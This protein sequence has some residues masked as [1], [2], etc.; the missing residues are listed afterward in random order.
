M[1]YKQSKIRTSKPIMLLLALVNF[2][3]IY[4]TNLNAEELIRFDKSSQNLKVQ[5]PLTPNEKNWIKN[6]DPIR[7]AVKSGWMPIEFQLENQLHRGYTIDFLQK[8]ANLY[9]I[10]FE[11]VDYSINIDSS[12]AD[13]ISSISGQNVSNKNFK[14]L[15]QP[16]LIIPNAIYIN[17]NHPKTFNANSLE[18]LKKASVAVYNKG[19][20]PKT[21]KNN[22][23]NLKLVTV[24]I[25]DEAF[26]YLKT[27]AIDAYVGNEFV[28]DYHIDAHHLSFVNKTGLTPFTS[29]ITMAVRD[30]QPELTSIMEKATSIIGQNNQELMKQWRFEKGNLEII[31]E[32][33]SVLIFL[34]FATGAI[35]YYKLKNNAAKALN[36]NQK[37]I[38]HQANFDYL[39]DLPNRNLLQNSLKH[40]IARADGNKSKVALI[41]IDLDNFKHINDNSGHSKGDE[42]LKASA[43]RIAQ[44][45]KMEDITARLGGD[46]FM[47]IVSDFED[48]LSIES[49]C[50]KILNSIQLPFEIGDESFFI[51]ASIGVTIFPDHSTDPEELMSYADQAMYESKKLGRNR[52][53]FFNQSLKIKIANKISMINDLRSAILNHQF[54]LYYQP[55][56][57]MNDS[58]RIK[59]EALIRWNHPQ[60]GIISPFDFIPLAEETGLIIE[61][62]DWIF[63]QATDD[64]KI[65]RNK[66]RSNFHLS[67]NVSPVQ[68]LKSESLTSLVSLVNK[69][70]IAGECICLEITEGLLLEPNPSVINTIKSLSE[71]GI[72]FSIDDFGTG[73]S[74]LA[75]LQKFKIDYLKIDKSFIQNLEKNN[76]DEALCG[77]IIQMAHKLG[78]NLIAEGVEEL[79]QEQ[80]LNAL[81]CDYVQGYLYGKPMTLVELLDLIGARNRTS[82]DNLN[83]KVMKF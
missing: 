72:K 57:K 48:E 60:K 39:T 9:R 30:D 79:K 69:K 5:I 13:I 40:S 81:G 44:C 16:F 38:W 64:L 25:A 77:F 28:V 59:A 29:Q 36:E 35:R 12:N 51:S 61:L 50:Q 21:L 56:I 54:E 15:S 82:N 22:F 19:I 68:F 24:D 14:L 1:Y 23:P 71:I 11:I 31:L 3:F 6:H 4:S 83:A 52:Y 33:I 63:D 78:I 27:G 62:G 17:K 66:T 10:N 34:S 47:I 32:I 18:D 65:I 55:I 80:I 67:I 20:L 46:E 70:N 73:Y 49:I 41:F 74:A 43:I 76:F 53:H 8:I 58:T 26:D 45:V 37:K 75:Y 2:L 7:V 42:L